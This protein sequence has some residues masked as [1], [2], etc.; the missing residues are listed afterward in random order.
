MTIIMS[1]MI[2]PKHKKTIILMNEVS[3]FKKM[4]ESILKLRH[5]L[6]LQSL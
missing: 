2:I 4:A 3:T 5:C 1:M 6:L